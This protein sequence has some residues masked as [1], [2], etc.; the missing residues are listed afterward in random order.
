ML[1]YLSATLVRSPLRSAVLAIGLLVAAVS[2]SLLTAAV[3]TSEAKVQ[4]TLNKNFRAAYDILVRPAGSQTAIERSSG[5]VRPNF[6]SGIYGGITEAQWKRILA[7]P[8]VDVAAPLA[9]AGIVIPYAVLPVEIPEAESAGGAGHLYRV[10]QSWTAVRGTS[11]YGGNRDFVYPATDPRACGELSDRAPIDPPEPQSAFDVAGPS[12]STLFC[13]DRGR[14]PSGATCWQLDPNYYGPAG[15]TVQ[16]YV[17]LAYPLAI[18]GI[19]PV[20][21]S[22]LLELDHTV[23]SGRALSENDTFTSN[24]HGSVVPVIASSRTYADIQLQLSVGQVQVPAGKNVPT[25][26]S[27]AGPATRAGSGAYRLLRSLPVTPGRT[28]RINADQLY[29]QALDTISSGFVNEYWTTGPVGY[30]RRKDG[31]LVPRTVEPDPNGYNDGAGPDGWAYV[32]PASD[33]VQYRPLQIHTATAQPNSQGNAGQGGVDI[34]GRFDP[35]KLPHFS[36]LSQVPLET[37]N[38]PVAQ[39]ADAATKQVLGGA[40]YR[41]TLNLGGYLTQPPQLLTTIAGIHGLTSSRYYQNGTDPSPI[42]VIRVRVAGVTGTDPLSLTRIKTV[43][44]QIHDRTGLDVDITAGSSP[45]PQLVQLHKSHFGTPALLLR[46]NWVAKGVAVAILSAID[47]KSLILLAMILLVTAVFLLNAGVASVRSRRSE[48]GTLLCLGWHPRQVAA[49]VFGELIVVG[50][51]AGALGTALAFGLSAGLGLNQ[52]AWRLALVA[53]VSIGLAAMAGLVPAIAAARGAPLDVAAPPVSVTRRPPRHDS[54]I[55]LAIGNLRGARGRT[56]LAGLALYIGVAAL[57]SLA[58]ITLAFRGTVVGTVLGDVVSVQVRG[59]DYVI[60]AL[61]LLLAAVA[62]TDVLVLG[63]RERA[64][65]LVTLRVLGW[66]DRQLARLILTEG[67]GIGLLSAGLGAITGA[68]IGLILGAPI[69]ALL[70][71]AALSAA[72]GVAA[73]AVAS[74]GPALAISR[75][76]IGVASAEA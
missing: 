28:I 20:Q 51:L 71:A 19:D 34:V 7:I 6:Q 55:T 75:L 72:I 64:V 17:T 56:L 38:P 40:P 68:V 12:F 33:D 2:F 26:L 57:A 13:Y 1:R 8:G 14:S 32:N 37:Y 44:A 74:L 21:E 73:A 60:V 27:S 58:A 45:A 67:L 69:T 31:V 25:L 43:A 36:P 66:S 9:N 50:V 23:V 16:A 70:T 22:K 3:Q 52:P 48:L 76:P 61:I 5:L 29:Q 54:M 53:P 46:E 47:R 35:A 49:S 39:G 62:L 18:A 65:E 15:C 11:Q 41:P 24:E 10:S 4:G 63:M 59:T 30:D 42:S